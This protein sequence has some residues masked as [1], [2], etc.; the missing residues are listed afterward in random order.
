MFDVLWEDNHLLFANKPAGVPVQGDSTGDQHFLEM[1]EEYIRVKYNKPG[2]AYV[3]LVHRIDRPVSGVVLFAKTS[4]ALTRLNDIFREKQNI[5]VYHALTSKPLTEESGTLEHYLSKDSETHRAHAYNQPRG[6][7][8][9]SVLHYKLLSSIAGRYLYEITLETGRFHQIRVQ[10]S[11]MGCPII[12]DLKYGAKNNLPDRSIALHANT[13]VTPHVVK[14][15][16]AVTVHAPY[17]RKQWWGLFKE[18][19]MK[20]GPRR[21]R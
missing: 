4:K 10:L 21:P 5:K 7:A 8:K 20:K 6:A 19:L 2:A 12:G 18:D 16:P 15:A 14:D 11:K 1:A 13:L 9:H 3:G 17:P